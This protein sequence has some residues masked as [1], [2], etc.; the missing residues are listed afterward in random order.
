[1]QTKIS[2]PS[3]KLKN[4]GRYFN[5]RTVKF[6]HGVN[7]LKSIKRTNC[8]DRYFPRVNSIFVQQLL[9]HGAIQ[10]RRMRRKPLLPFPKNDIGKGTIRYHPPSNNQNIVTISP[11]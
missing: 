6:K 4:Y 7:N 3:R 2:E 11:L 1:M 8:V 9:T 5:F 10:Q